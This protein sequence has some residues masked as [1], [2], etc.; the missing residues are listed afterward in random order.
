[1]AE[2]DVVVGSRAFLPLL[3]PPP[4]LLLGAVKAVS[5]SAGAKALAADLPFD[6]VVLDVS[7]ACRGFFPL[8]TGQ[9]PSAAITSARSDSVCLCN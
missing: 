2:V 1:L 6:G 4:L 5:R 8:L 7:C 9:T 3:P